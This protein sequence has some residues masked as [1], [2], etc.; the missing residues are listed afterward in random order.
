MI[1]LD[2][3]TSGL[4]FVKNGIWQIGA[5]DFS[6]GKIFLDES[7]LDRDDEIDPEALKIIGKT[8][9]ELRDPNKQNQKQMLEKFFGWVAEKPI[10][11]YICQNPQ[12]DVAFIDTKA[13][14]YGL[15]TPHGYRAFDLHSFAQK[16]YFDRNGG[17]FIEDGK[18]KMNLQSICS[19]CG[20]NYEG[21]IIN[22]GEVTKQ[23]KPHNA[24]EDAKLTA[25]CFSRLVYGKG[26]FEEYFDYEMPENL[27][28]NKK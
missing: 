9:Q 17:F 24:L 25:E 23:G 7:R 20:L 2:I 10:R 26:L 22:K 11:N 12:F 21:I 16:E 27:R 6:T 13:R 8:E 19:M 28:G 5:Y 1:V 4:D 3:E 14:K 15:K 18:S